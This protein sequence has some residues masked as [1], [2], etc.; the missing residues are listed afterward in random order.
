[1]LI[2]VERNHLAKGIKFMRKI[3]QNRSLP[4]YEKKESSL[5]SKV[6]FALLITGL[7]ILG[8][9][10]VCHAQEFSDVQIVNAIFLAEGGYHARY[11]YGIRSISCSTMEAC[12][13]ICKNT[14]RN[15]RKRF[16]KISNTY[17]GNFI[18]YLGNRYCPTKG[19]TLTQNEVS[20]NQY[21]IKNVTYF[22]ERGI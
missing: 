5:L 7:V 3:L 6:M 9:C 11:P 17:I 12:R 22:L 2:Q 4:E 10:R 21:W 18:T 16:A 19:R 1:M 8:S 14:V 15:N 20:L 13:Q